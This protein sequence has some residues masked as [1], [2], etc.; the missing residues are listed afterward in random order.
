[1]TLSRKDIAALAEYQRKHGTTEGFV[2][3]HPVKRRK[4][5]EWELQRDF[6]AWWREA[7]WNGYG[8][9]PR[10]CF[11]IPNGAQLGENK[12]AKIIRAK[13]LKA[14]GMQNGIPDVCLLVKR[15]DYG[16]LFMEFKTESGSLSPD[17]KTIHPVITGAGYQVRIVRTLAEAKWTVENY[18]RI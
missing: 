16:A 10:L 6:F 17:Q 4:N 18:L 11:A 12:E 2:P 5:E 3:A 7:A 15:G 9:D 14:A 13:M 8:L 1:M